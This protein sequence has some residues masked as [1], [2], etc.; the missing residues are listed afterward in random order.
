MSQNYMRFGSV[1][2]IL[3][4][5]FMLAAPL[6]AT[7]SSAAGTGTADDPYDGYTA[8]VSNSKEIYVYRG[9]YIDVTFQPEDDFDDTYLS[10][11]QGSGTLSVSGLRIYGT[12]TADTVKA[13]VDGV[14][15]GEVYDICTLTIHAVDTEVGTTTK[16]SVSNVYV[17]EGT[18]FSFT[19]NGTVENGEEYRAVVSVMAGKVTPTSVGD[20]DTVTYTAPNVTGRMSFTIT[21]TS[22]VEGT[23]QSQAKVTVWVVDKL[24]VSAPAVGTISSS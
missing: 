3:C 20:G 23:V 21:V 7:E 13:D 5:A 8:T 17:V 2:S 22:D 6:V 19:V 10:L 14:F 12:L 1:M 18:T 24:T 9:G 16:T 4:L 11:V 15:E